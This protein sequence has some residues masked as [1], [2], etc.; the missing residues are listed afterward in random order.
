MVY[1][2]VKKNMQKD[3]CIIYSKAR[4]CS[5]CIFETDFEG[6]SNYMT[7]GVECRYYEDVYYNRKDIY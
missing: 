6:E 2:P 7:C 5:S 3:S 1:Y 4:P